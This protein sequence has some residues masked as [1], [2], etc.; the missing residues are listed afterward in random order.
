MFTPELIAAAEQAFARVRGDEAIRCVVVTGEGAVFSMGGTPEALR[1]LASGNGRFSDAPVVYEGM[2]RCGRP[3]VVAMQGHAAGGGLA[4]GLYGDVLI[5]SRTGEYRANFIDYGFTPGMGATH[6]LERKL[7]A[8]VAAEMML[9]A[10]AFTGA[11]LAQRGADVAVLDTA[12]VLPAALRMARSIA[13]KPEAAVR[14]LKSELAGRTLEV[15]PEIIAREVSLHEDV[16]DRGAAELVATRLGGQ[17]QA[18]DRQAPQP[19]APE[20]KTPEPKT[21]EPKTPELETAEPAPADGAAATGPAAVPPIDLDEVRRTVVQ[22]VSDVLYLDEGEIDLAG[23]FAEMG[24]D[25][26]GVVELISKLNREWQ[27]DLESVAVYSH[28]TIDQLTELVAAECRGAAALQ[29]SAQQDDSAQDEPAQDEPAQDELAQDELA[30]HDPPRVSAPSDRASDPDAGRPAAFP[31]PLLVVEPGGAPAASEPAVPGPAG[32]TVTLRALNPSPPA[33]DGPP[34]DSPAVTDRQEQRPLPDVPPPDDDDDNA[35]AII[36]LAAR[37]PDAADSDAFWQNLATGHCAIAEVPAARWD[38]TGHFQPGRVGAGT[39]N[40]KWAALLDRI[41]TFDERFFRLSPLD[42]QAMDPQQRLFLEETWHALE[43]AGYAAGLAGP[44]RHWGVFV[45]CG[46]GDYADLLA[47]GGQNLTGQAFLGNAP[48][49]LPA[50]IAYLLNMTGPTMA[51]DTAC[52]SSLVAV[53]LAAAAIRRGECELALAGGVA[54]MCTEKMQVWTSQAGMLSPAGRCR[55]F[56]VSADGIVLGEGVGVVVLKRL[57]RA[58][59]DGDSIRGVILGSGINGDGKSNGITAPN[60][61]AQAELLRTVYDSCGVAAA[62]ITYVETHGTGTRL[63]DPIEVGALNTVYGA[64]GR[65]GTPCELGSVK[66]NI[67][68]TTMAAGVAGLV[69]VLLALQHGQLPPSGGYTG[70]PNDEIDFGA[71]PFRVVTELKSWPPGSS[72][73]RIAAISSFGFSGTNCHLVVTE[74]PQ[75]PSERADTDP[76]LVLLSAR[77]IDELQAIVARLADRLRHEPPRLADLAF[78]LAVGRAAL[79]QRAAFVATSPADLLAG[80]SGWQPPDEG[81]QAASDG[82]LIEELMSRARESRLASDLQSLADAY[83]AGADAD[84]GV[85]FEGRDLRRIPLPGYPFAPRSHW[86]QAR[87]ERGPAP[88]GR[89]GNETIDAET[90]DAETIDAESPLARGHKVAGRTVLPAAASIGLFAAK[91]RE[92]DERP[93]VVLDGIRW[94]RPVLLDEAAGTEVE[95]RIDAEGHLT[96]TTAGLLSV[97]AR[98]VD[99]DASREAPSVDV[100]AVAAACPRAMDVEELYRD[101]AAS[102][103]DYGGD[104]RALSALWAG[105]G[106][107]LATLRTAAAANAGPAVTPPATALDGAIQAAAALTLSDGQQLLPFSADRAE[108]RTASAAPRYSVVHA[109]G[110]RRFDVD[111]VT[112]DGSVCVAVRGL[113]LRAAPGHGPVILRPQWVEADPPAQAADP[114]AQAA[115]LP[116]QAARRL[117][118][119]APGGSRWW[120]TPAIPWPRH[121]WPARITAGCWFSPATCSR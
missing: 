17:P 99:A 103:L 12:E 61:H 107:A 109:R 51:V 57:S 66:G 90:I 87:P 96:L 11:E 86:V 50:R 14:A 38:L 30:Q 53:H 40:S 19:R 116:A 2:L 104:F 72:G 101:F 74:P 78:T 9:T 83:R 54:V 45:G 41:D 114:P 71:G 5:M 4:F 7:G 26:V 8:S 33:E 111:V 112:G 22:V 21:P 43:D 34:A 48:S 70:A 91:A 93:A 69:K 76:E 3:V 13:R 1:E 27:I 28:P 55:P 115:G 15:L 46:A 100:E 60:G 97:T 110:P 105:N 79:G 36:G 68:H 32:Q 29:D 117:P 62:D 23:P 84:W 73:R 63:G 25:S 88:S 52:S 85:L 77:T 118:V 119:R 47:G 59:A 35:V 20:P 64:P 56:D 120:A 37:F 58:L 18:P 16:L 95:V 121:C 39:T 31:A 6:I 113:T 89:A 49:V 65:D 75:P 92:A 102:G 67:G 108:V 81:D 44:G 106:V 98:A 82:L 10:R 80:L 42:A 94:L 24:L